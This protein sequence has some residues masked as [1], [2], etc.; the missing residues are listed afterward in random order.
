MNAEDRRVVRTRRLLKAAL[1]ELVDEQP[2][3]EITIREVTDRAD[4]GY[5]TF[6]RHYDGVDDL[7]LE[8][9]SET[10]EELESLA[11]KHAEGYFQREGFLLFKH[12]SDNAPLYRGILDSHIFAHK[13]R[14]HFMQ[15]VRGQL[16]GHADELSASP[17]PLDIAAL[18]MVSSLLGLI[19][20]WLAAGA[21]YSIERMAMIYD[22]LVIQAT[23]YALRQGSP[24]LPKEPATV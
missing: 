6:F 1:L 4:I 16:Q 10:V 11:Q 14:D 20:W 21:P 8:I 18:H 17:I 12:V 5:A 24:G 7:M 19:E 15:V 22:R 9:F 13:L 2:Y 3:K 23:W